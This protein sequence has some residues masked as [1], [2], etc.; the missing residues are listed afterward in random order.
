MVD[1][2]RS[3]TRTHHT[4]HPRHGGKTGR[5]SFPTAVVDTFHRRFPTH[6][7]INV[8]TVG[9]VH[10]GDAYSSMIKNRVPETRRIAGNSSE[11]HRQS[12]VDT[13]SVMESGTPDP[14]N[15][16][17]A[18]RPTRRRLPSGVS[19]PEK[20]W[21]NTIDKRRQ[22]KKN[23][24]YEGTPHSKVELAYPYFFCWLHYTRFIELCWLTSDFFRAVVQRVKREMW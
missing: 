9:T 20:K 4:K 1:E 11:P 3:Q 6:L 19:S 18:Q 5:C 12:S 14:A 10:A 21:R 13:E 8:Q 22:S 15:V 17:H 7:S 16:H 2:S 23:A 24:S